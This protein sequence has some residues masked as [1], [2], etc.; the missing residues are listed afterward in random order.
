MIIVV[1]V[2]IRVRMSL[3]RERLAVAKAVAVMGWPRRW[4]GL[5]GARVRIRNRRL[6]RARVSKGDN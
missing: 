1:R 6:T 4:M 3:A 2:R 5:A